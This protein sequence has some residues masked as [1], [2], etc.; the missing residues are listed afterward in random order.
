IA[1]AVVFG[2][3]A[4]RRATLKSRFGPEYERTV[5]EAG[6]ARR[7]ES[8]LETRAQRVAKYEIRQLRP[9]EGAQFA[10]R[11]RQVQSR[12]VDDPAAAVADAD[13]L[14]TELMR[15]RGYPMNEFDRRAE[16]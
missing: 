11:W 9:D 13:A 12:F 14:V 10:S 8:A 6:S 4:R 15:A 3:F 1:A 16:D 7:A 2:Y 5:R